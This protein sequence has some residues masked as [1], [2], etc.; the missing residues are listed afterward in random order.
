MLKIPSNQ[1]LTATCSRVRLLIMEKKDT[2]WFDSSGIDWRHFEMYIKLPLIFYCK[3][4]ESVF[5]LIWQHFMQ[6]I[7]ISSFVIL[8]ALSGDNLRGNSEM[9]DINILLYIENNCYWRIL[10][11]IY[12]IYYYN[13]Y[14]TTYKWVP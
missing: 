8:T 5:L 3:Y 4:H 2:I 9:C 14:P 7:S 6:L 11:D 13:Y 10:R 12:I 1:N